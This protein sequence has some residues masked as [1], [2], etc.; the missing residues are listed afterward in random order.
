MCTLLVAFP[1]AKQ[2][3]RIL[4]MHLTILF[5]HPRSSNLQYFLL[6]NI[7]G[8]MSRSGNVDVLRWNRKCFFFRHVQIH[9]WYNVMTVNEI[10][11]DRPEVTFSFLIITGRVFFM[12]GWSIPFV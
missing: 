7:Q 8:C 9:S 4:S 5:I 6:H 2:I 12:I 3:L 10:S 11:R 1:L